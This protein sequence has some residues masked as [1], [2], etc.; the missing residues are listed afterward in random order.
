MI[1]QDDN[2]M[3]TSLRERALETQQSVEAVAKL[4][5]A[6]HRHKIAAI[7]SQVALTTETNEL[8]KKHQE[9]KALEKAHKKGKGGML[10][11]LPLR[12]LAQ[13]QLSRTTSHHH[14]MNQLPKLMLQKQNLLRV[15][16]NG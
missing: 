4:V 14:H 3:E 16:G 12:I 15:K 6:V 10:K 7:T 11:I 5:D 13:L 1:K 2:T 8:K 9:F